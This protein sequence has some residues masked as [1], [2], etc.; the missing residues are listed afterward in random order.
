MPLNALKK[1]ESRATSLESNFRA[2]FKDIPTTM[3]RCE[4]N[5]A[6]YQ[7]MRSK[8]ID[9]A[10]NLHETKGVVAGLEGAPKILD[11]FK[12][13]AKQAAEKEEVTVEEAKAR[14]ALVDQCQKALMATAAVKKNEFVSNVGT[15]NG[16]VHAA[17]YALDQIE[18]SINNHAMHLRTNK[19]SN[20]RDIREGKTNS[21]KIRE[22]KA[23]KSSKQKK[24]TKKE[25]VVKQTLASDP[26]KDDPKPN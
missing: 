25:Q 26:L 12:I 13:I 5:L 2:V 17:T 20:L 8:I 9:L 4:T 24:P 19:G 3:T 7:A 1:L 14:I 6:V 18:Q 15:A 16:I 11:Q 10:A 22:E 21:Q 23:A